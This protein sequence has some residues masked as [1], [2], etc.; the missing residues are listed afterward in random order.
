MEE[1]CPEKLKSVPVLPASSEAEG[2]LPKGCHPPQT[3]FLSHPA[4]L[5]RLTIS[6]LSVT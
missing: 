5:H 6:Y 1:H 3:P 4:D 2:S